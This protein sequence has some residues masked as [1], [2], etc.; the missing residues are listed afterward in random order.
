MLSWKGPEFIRGICQLKWEM[1]NYKER[2]GNRNLNSCLLRE[3]TK[4]NKDL[5]NRNRVA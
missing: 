2:T 4:K 1:D 3:H 5:Q